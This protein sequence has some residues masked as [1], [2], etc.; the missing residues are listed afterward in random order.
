MA[1]VKQVIVLS[2]VYDTEEI[3]GDSALSA[4]DHRLFNEDGVIEWDAVIKKE[5]TL[6]ANITDEDLED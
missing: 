1:V 3:Y 5:E 2:V 6:S 4:I